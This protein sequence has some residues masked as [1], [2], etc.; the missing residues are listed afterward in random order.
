MTTNPDAP[1]SQP[2]VRHTDDAHTIDIAD[3]R[4]VAG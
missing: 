1:Q 3:L 2:V 4:T